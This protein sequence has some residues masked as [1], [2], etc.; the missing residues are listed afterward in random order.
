[1]TQIKKKRIVFYKQHKIKLNGGNMKLTKTELL[2]LLDTLQPTIHDYETLSKREQGSDKDLAETRY[3]V[4][5][6]LY[7][8][9]L[10]VERGI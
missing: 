2:V 10:E 4:L 5:T 3:A 1:L 8:R 9:L 6:H 7:D